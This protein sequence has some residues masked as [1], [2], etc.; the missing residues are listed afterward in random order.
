MQWQVNNLAFA[1]AAYR[2][3]H[4]TYP[5]K[6]A[7]LKPKYVKTIPTDMFN[8]DA[9]L[10]YVRKGGGYRLYSVGPNGI[11]DGGRGYADRENS[12]DPASNEWDDIGVRVGEEK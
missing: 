12:T 10:H 7:D 2:A 3:D 8:G 1:L 4:G 11:D 6:L 9:D 5:A